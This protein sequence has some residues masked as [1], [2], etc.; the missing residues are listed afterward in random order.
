MMQCVAQVIR[1][2][3]GPRVMSPTMRVFYVTGY[4]LLAIGAVAVL[5]F[6]LVAA[7]AS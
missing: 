5:L 4:V 3:F 2:G 6:A 7:V 1:C